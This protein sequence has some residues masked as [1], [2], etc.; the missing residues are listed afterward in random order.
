MNSTTVPP[1][2]IAPAQVS[3]GAGVLATLGATIAALGKRPLVI[4]GDRSLAQAAPFL[5]PAIQDLAALTT[6]YGAD[7]S[8]AT[9]ARLAVAIAEHQADLVIGVG[10]GKALDT[11]KLAAHQ[12]Q[13]PV[14]TIPTSAATCAAW[15]ALSNVYSE[16]GAFLY[17]VALARC[18][19]LLILD[20]DLVATA[21]QRTLVAGIGDALAKWYEGS[22][23]SGDSVQTLVIA[24]VQQARVLRDL[25]LQKTPAALAEEPGGATWCEVVDACVLLAGVMGGLGG[26]QCRTVAAHAVHNGLT[27]LPESHGILH[28]EKVAYGILVQLRLEEI[29]QQSSLAYTARQQLIQ[30]YEATGL[31]K[32]LADMG[33]DDVRIS[34]LGRAAEITCRP[35]SDIHHL[36]FSVTPEALMGALM[37]TTALEMKVKKSGAATQPSRRA[38]K[39][40]VRSR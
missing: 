27:H 13:L 39:S 8:E 20:Y 33:M 18:P 21:P 23:S 32:T 19:D 30:F 29:A 16:Q 17:D 10:G 4:G 34:D 26:A 9:L 37:T 3:R 11:A 35:Q 12:A 6:S 25:L 7:C 36:P 1:L 5:D 2:M 24:A 14:V 22:V 38:E 31:P 28:G 40:A 15:T